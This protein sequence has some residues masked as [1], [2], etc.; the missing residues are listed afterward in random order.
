MYSNIARTSQRKRKKEKFVS[1][2]S[3]PRGQILLELPG[4]VLCRYLE[5]FA[6]GPFD[7]DDRPM[8]RTDDTGAPRSERD[9]VC[10]EIE[11]HGSEVGTE[12]VLE[13]RVGLHEGS[14]RQGT[15][16]RSRASSELNIALNAW[17][18]L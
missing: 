8:G 14:K 17:P 4:E 15:G 5:F 3:S 6:L 7:I 16:R 12:E 13:T 18:M 10:G 9:A 2:S 11:M 1:K